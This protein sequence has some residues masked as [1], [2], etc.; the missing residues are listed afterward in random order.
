VLAAGHHA[1]AL[2][3]LEGTPVA[4]YLL[5]ARDS[6]CMLTT[7]SLPYHQSEAGTHKWVHCQCKRYAVSELARPLQRVLAHWEV[8]ASHA[9]L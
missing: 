2:R 3:I 1:A 9:A 5:P 7:Q 8:A 4:P 6:S